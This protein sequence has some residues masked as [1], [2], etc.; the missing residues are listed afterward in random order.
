MVNF[1]FGFW[2]NTFKK[3]RVFGLSLGLKENTLYTDLV[4]LFWFFGGKKQSKQQ[5]LGFGFWVW[6]RKKHTKYL[7]LRGRGKIIES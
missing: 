3:S 4:F 7:V 6:R 5:L 2:E 1:G